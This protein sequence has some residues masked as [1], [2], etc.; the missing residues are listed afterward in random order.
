MTDVARTAPARGGTEMLLCRIRD[1]VCGLPLE[2]VVETMRPLP[3]EP[4]GGG[5]AFVLGLSRIRGKPVPV[6][7]LARLVTGTDGAQ[8]TRFVTVRCN[9]RTVALRVDAVLGVAALTDPPSELP[10]LLEGDHAPVAALAARDRALLLVLETAR[11]MPPQ[12]A[13]KLGNEAPA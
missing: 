11:L 3:V 12:F 5:P 7:D 1:V 4:L 9:D 8:P 13:D 10:P 2:H 6:V